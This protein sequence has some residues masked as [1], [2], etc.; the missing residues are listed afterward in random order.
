MFETLSKGFRAA[1]ERLT[2]IAE[3]TEDNIEAALRDVRM[4]LL[5]ADVA[6]SVTKAFLGRVK[7]K[8][9]GQVFCGDGV[10]EKKLG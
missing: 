5:E 9:L 8:A 10:H 4:S 3:L 7:D 1:R 6:F 2:G